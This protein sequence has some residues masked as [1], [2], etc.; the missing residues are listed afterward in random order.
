MTWAERSPHLPWSRH[1]NLIQA[2]L[3]C[4]AFSHSIDC[5]KALIH[6]L[7][8][9]LLR[10]GALQLLFVHFSLTRPSTVTLTVFL[11][12]SLTHSHTLPHSHTDPHTP[13]HT[14][15]HTLSGIGSNEKSVVSS[16]EYDKNRIE[17]LRLMIA[18]FSDSLYQVSFF[19]PCVILAL[20]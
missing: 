14:L 9:F 4:L 1:F 6:R 10:Y 18:A 5:L 7:E 17:V 2:V 13:T 8:W 12:E 16:T 11:T 3:S 19:T 15:T 20:R